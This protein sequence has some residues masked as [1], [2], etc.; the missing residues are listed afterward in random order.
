MRWKIGLLVLAL[1]AM[2]GSASYYYSNQPTYKIGDCL[3][4]KAPDETLVFLVEILDN[5]GNDY[6]F[7]IYFHVFKQENTVK[8]IDF[9]ALMKKNKAEKV[10][11]KDWLQD[12]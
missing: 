4:I 2:L 9:E 1:L 3:A 11:C 8:K 5:R 6:K 10:D 12:K 7:N